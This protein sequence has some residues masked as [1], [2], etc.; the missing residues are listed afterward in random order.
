[1]IK[2]LI[3]KVLETVLIGFSLVLSFSGKHAEAAGCI[4]FAAYLAINRLHMDDAEK[5]GE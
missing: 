4:A 1:M 3:M 2:A 5:E